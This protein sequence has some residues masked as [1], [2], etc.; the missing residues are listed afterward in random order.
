[1]KETLDWGMAAAMGTILL[2]SVLI[3][4]WI[5]NKLLGIDNLKLG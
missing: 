2:V 4:Y 3:L 1:M 5:Y